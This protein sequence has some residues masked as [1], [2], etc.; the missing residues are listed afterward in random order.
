MCKAIEVS[1]KL[2]KTDVSK[3]SDLSSITIRDEIV[4]VNKYVFVIS[5]FMIS[6]CFKEEMRLILKSLYGNV[7][8]KEQRKK[9]KDS[10]KNM[11]KIQKDCEKIYKK[12]ENSYMLS[13]SGYRKDH[14]TRTIYTW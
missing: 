8:G 13:F 9:V 2:P 10:I 12:F 1:K 4:P 7:S 3:F 11:K 5:C 14:I 6:E